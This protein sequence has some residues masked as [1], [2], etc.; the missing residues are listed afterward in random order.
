VEFP[1]VLKLF[2]STL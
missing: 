1:K 2:T